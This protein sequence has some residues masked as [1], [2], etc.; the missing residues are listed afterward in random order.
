MGHVVSEL[1]L[2]IDENKVVAVLLK[3]IP[4][5]KKEIESFL[6]FSGYYRQH[7][8]DFARI[9]KSL[10]K[11]CDQQKVCEMTE[12]RVQSYEELEKSLTKF[13]LTLM[14]DWKRP[15]KLQIECL[16]RRIRCFT[17]PKR[18]INDKPAAGSIC[19]ISSKIQTTEARYREIQIEFLCQV[20]ALEKLNYY[21][22]EKVFDVITDCN[23]VRYLLSMNPPNRLMLRWK[24]AI[25]E[26]TGN[27]IIVHKHGKIDKNADGLSRWALENTPENS[28]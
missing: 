10:Y 4:Q 27:M 21:L 2:V 16:W 14:P 17:K 22:D 1:S 23:S 28:A 26:Y 8:T 25:Q 12:E 13:Q 7:I 11:I 24:I 15:F 3:P 19:F 6:G 9:S 5:T 18:M 20:W